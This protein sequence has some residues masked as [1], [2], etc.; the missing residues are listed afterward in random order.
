MAGAGLQAAGLLLLHTVIAKWLGM[1]VAFVLAQGL[2]AAAYGAWGL[3]VF[4]RQST[5]LF[6]VLARA[7]VIYA[8]LVLAFFATHVCD[9]TALG[10]IWLLAEALI[11]GALGAYELRMLRRG[12]TFVNGR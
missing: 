7:N 10:R 12:L 2:I 6:G 1:P 11:V 5:S 8:A 9:V 3:M 4:L